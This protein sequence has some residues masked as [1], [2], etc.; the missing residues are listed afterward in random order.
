M[1]WA[2]E[3]DRVGFL[4]TSLIVYLPQSINLTI[5]KHTSAILLFRLQLD[6]KP[7][8][9]TQTGED[10]MN[11]NL[12]TPLVAEG[13]WMINSLADLKHILVTLLSNTDRTDD[14]RNDGVFAERNF[15]HKLN[16]FT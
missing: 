6:V 13:E 8:C 15:W 2:G 14:H 9:A 10:E 16:Q 5:T 7:F 11:G 3:W 1:E 12:I 4:N